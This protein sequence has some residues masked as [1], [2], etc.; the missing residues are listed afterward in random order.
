[1]KT[2]G[3]NC[4]K[5]ILANRRVSFAPEAT[6]HTWDVVELPEDSTT[7][8]ANST[9]RAS[10]MSAVSQSPHPQ[11]SSGPSTDASEPPSTPPEQIEETTVKASPAHQRD[12]HQK[13]RRRSSGIPPMNFNNPDDFSSSPYSGSSAADDDTG[14]RSLAGADDD[15]TSNSEDDDLIEGESTVTGIDVDGDDLTG[16][17]VGSVHSTAS[18]TGSS[19]RLEAA[20]RQA[21]NQAGTQGI[22]YDEHGDI[23]MEMADD[24]V[25]AAFQPWVKKGVYMPNT[26]G[27]LSAIQDQENLN[28]FSPAFKANL[29]SKKTIVE[30]DQEQTMDFTQAAGAILPSLDQ[31]Q[32]SP[33]RGS[34]KSGATSQRRSS[35][36]RRRSSGDASVPEDQTMEFTTAVGGIQPGPQALIATDHGQESADED[37]E[38]TM[39]FTSVVGGL[40]NR[41][42]DRRGSLVSDQ[43]ASEQLLQEGHRRESDSSLMQ[44]EDMDMTM[45]IGGILPSITEQTEP[46]EDDTMAMDVTT[47]IGAIL[48]K[49]LSIGTKAQAKDLMERETD[50]GQFSSAQLQ[51]EAFSFS[52]MATPTT[53]L[54]AMASETGSPSLSTHN[55]R[56]STRRSGGARQSTTPK[57]PSQQGTPLK[58]PSTPSKQLTPKPPRPTTPGKTPPSKNVSM[59]TGSPKKLFRSEIR[60]A[61]STP[62]ASSRP[63]IFRQ[64]LVSGLAT[65]S[66][67][68]TPHGRG[69]SGIGI[70]QVGLGSPRVAALLDRRGSIGEHAKVFTSQGRAAPSVRFEDPRTMEQEIER[71]RDEE[72]RRE[73][74]R[75]ILQREAEGQDAEEERDATVNLKEMIESLTPKKKKLQGRKS[76]HV[77]AA[78]GLL[79]KRPVELDEDEEDTDTPPKRLKGREGSPVKNV[80]LP[81]PPSKTETTGRSSR[82]ARLSLAETVGNIQPTTPTTTSSPSKDTRITTP[83]DQGRFKD[84]ELHSSSQ[85]PLTSFNEKLAGESEVSIQ[86]DEE[87]DRIHLQ[88][89]LNMTSIRFMELTTTKRRHTVAPNAMLDDSARKPTRGGVDKESNREFEKC[90]VAGACTVPMLELYQHVNPTQW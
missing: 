40:I 24:E 42:P 8:S 27:D 26:M 84:V 64:D 41:R 61:A 33:A 6:L 65:P 77:G 85:K 54:T 69:F 86:P 15:S 30:D 32:G 44:E 39:E 13:K 63:S 9:R 48:P 43:L 75:G 23:T 76:L 90:V 11:Q 59:R 62:E 55:T 22:E 46:I 87:D 25:T 74:G 37:E 2:F 5:Q 56:N 78:R 3:I 7:S 57:A 4:A 35:A 34:R 70:D 89:F 50:A 73:S 12:L 21:A 18:S 67:V 19:G 28:P 29:N 71:E 66:V 20:L 17:S 52:K 36:G 83:K 60:H 38:L 79:G 80:K 81:G 31:S 88:D 47:A 68:L 1:M 72:E 82:A 53:H 16:Q 45:A 14:H 58:K 51:E 10:A 49:Q